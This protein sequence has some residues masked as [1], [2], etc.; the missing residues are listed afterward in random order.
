MALCQECGGTILDGVMSCPGCG[1]AV[2]RSIPCAGCGFPAQPGMA[3]CASCGRHLGRPFACRTNRFPLQG[4]G[5]DIGATMVGAP[6]S[7]SA[8]PERPARRRAFR[9]PAL[10]AK[11]TDPLFITA[12]LLAAASVAFAWMPRYNVSLAGAALI[13]SLL[14]YMRFFSYKHRGR[15]GGL[16]MNYIATAIGISGLVAGL[17]LT[18]FNW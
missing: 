17:G 13:A 11:R 5:G 16:W 15:Y 8:W 18:A 6:D 9:L 4:S 3:R 14:G 7:D 1:K 2:D 10:G 12:L